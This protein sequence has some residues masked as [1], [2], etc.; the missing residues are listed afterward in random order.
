MEAEAAVEKVVVPEKTIALVTK[1]ATEGMPVE[2]LVVAGVGVGAA[3]ATA[4]AAAMAQLVRKAG[5][6]HATVSA[7]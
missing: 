3:T 1:T 5:S 4:I 6:P 2:M 7:A